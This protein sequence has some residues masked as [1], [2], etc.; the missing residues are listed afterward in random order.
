MTKM[1]KCEQDFAVPYAD[2]NVKE[3]PI[4]KR[5]FVE[6]SAPDADGDTHWRF[7]TEA[8]EATYHAAHDHARAD[9]DGMGAAVGATPAND[10]DA[11]EDDLGAKWGSVEEEETPE[12]KAI[13]ETMA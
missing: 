9:D 2:A 10:D 7:L 5:L 1:F 12:A 13:R 3:G 11:N 8:E 4:S 6:A